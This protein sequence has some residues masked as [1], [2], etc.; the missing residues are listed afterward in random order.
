VYIPFSLYGIDTTGSNYTVAWQV[1]LR[2]NSADNLL[3]VL[4]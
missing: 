4:P 1:H 2:F 3:C